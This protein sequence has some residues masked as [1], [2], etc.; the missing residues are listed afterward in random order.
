[1]E[2]AR[3]PIRMMPARAAYRTNPA[4]KDEV[5]QVADPVLTD[6]RGE[7]DGKRNLP[8]YCVVDAGERLR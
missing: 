3:I 5:R 8:D 7:S 4:T 1:M 6:E 2:T